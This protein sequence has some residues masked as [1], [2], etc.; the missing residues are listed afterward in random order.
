MKKRETK[1]DRNKRIIS[2]L[3][4][5]CEKNDV[6]IIAF[7]Q[8]FGS[9]CL[10]KGTADR[11]GLIYAAREEQMYLK[12]LSKKR[13]EELVAGIN[14]PSQQPLARKETYFG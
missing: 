5:V 12:A 10:A 6:S 7:G 9:V 14:T 2:E 1:P 13:V 11:I 3:L 4:N 8:E